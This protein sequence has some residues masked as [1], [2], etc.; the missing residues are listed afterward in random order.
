MTGARFTPN[1]DFLPYVEVALGRSLTEMVGEIAV[2]AR[3]RSHSRRVAASIGIEPAGMT[4]GGPIVATC[5]AA[6]PLAAIMEH[7]TG[8]R[9]QTTT[10]RYTGRMPAFPFMG[11]ARDEV[12]ARGLP[13]LA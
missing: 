11:P 3:A 6:N 8:D 7:G 2:R 10:G 12:V 1:P 5:F 4:I 9:T 13:P